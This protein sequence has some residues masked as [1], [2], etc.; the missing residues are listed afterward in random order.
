MIL[1]PG[2]RG[3]VAAARIWPSPEYTRL[4]IESESKIRYTVFSISSPMRLVLDL[5][6]TQAKDV[7][8]TL[9]TKVLASDPLVASIRVGQFSP[10]RARVVMDLKKPVSPKV[11]ALDPYPPY[12]HRLVVDLW[13]RENPDRL[14]AL[15]K[16]L[17]QKG[18]PPPGMA[19]AAFGRLSKPAV[20]RLAP[21]PFFPKKPSSFLVMVDPGHGGEDPGAVGPRGTHEK[22][23][24]LAIAK[25]LVKKIADK[26]M[27]ARLTREG[28][29]F[30]PLVGRVAKARASKADL[31]V[32]IHADAA[33][34]RN[35]E[36]ASVYIL[37]ERGATSV[38][39]RTLAQRE[40][41]SDLI[42]GVS[43]KS[44]DAYLAKTLLDLS[45]TASVAASMR[46]G[47]AVLNEIGKSFPLHIER[48]EQA[49]FAVLKAPDIPSIL[50]ETA[51]ISNYEEE[52]R[53]NDPG[54]QEAMAGSIASAI[55]SFQD[56]TNLRAYASVAEER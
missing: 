27:H 2:A 6:D 16:D 39:A 26:G 56:K 24:V 13:P 50:V 47:K 23:V 32:S 51:F 22:D 49:G 33:R 10:T 52:R 28:D 37:S 15:V 5:E 29:Y 21:T 20:N 36:G 3:K 8:R 9:P 31:F 7:L 19:L 12:G 48:I 25:R 35:A 14:L 53:L 11:F 30:I 18:S 54:F 17:E 41:A 42:G 55:F 44:Q 38:Q 4:A 34:N 40:N 45:Q 46:L 43:L 1:A